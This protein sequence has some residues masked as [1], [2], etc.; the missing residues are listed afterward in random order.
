MTKRGRPRGFDRQ[1]ALGRA[2]DVFWALGYEGATLTDLQEAMGGISAP[3]FYAA[4][5]SKEQLFR[6]VIEYYCKSEGTPT[7]RALTETATARASIQAMLLAAIEAICQPGKPRGCMLVLGAINCAQENQGVQDHLR[8]MR[9]QAQK[10]IKQRLDRG[11]T[12]GD[13]STEVDRA[14]LASFYTTVLHGLSIQAR[15][16]A[17]RKAL[18]AAVSCAMAAWNQLAP[19]EGSTRPASPSRAEK[20]R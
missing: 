10:Y 4:F 11:A 7:L 12:E 6:E 14:A 13:L 15:D 3:S 19:E 9:L 18:M 17:P 1:E 16:G 20:K 5:G 8:E 2:R